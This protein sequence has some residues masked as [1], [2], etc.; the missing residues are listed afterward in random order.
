MLASSGWTIPSTLS[1]CWRSVAAL[2]AVLWAAVC[3]GA[4]GRETAAAA[5][6]AVGGAGI[7]GAIVNA[8]WKKAD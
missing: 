7:I 2:G 8:R 1:V 3:L 6:A 4:A 5:V